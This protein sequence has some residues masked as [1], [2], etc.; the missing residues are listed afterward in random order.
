MVLMVDEELKK[1]FA[2]IEDEGNAV[3][4]ECI[5]TACENPVCTCGNVYLDLIPMQPYDDYKEHSHHRK[6]E[7]DID[8][9]TLGYKNAKKIPKEGNSPQ[10]HRKWSWVKWLGN[11]VRAFK[12]WATD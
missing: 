8:E 3:K 12:L 5:L 6:I 2:T 11:G 1:L 10:R 9:K 4:Y 7:I